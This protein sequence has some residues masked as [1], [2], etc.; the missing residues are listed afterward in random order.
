MDG[1]WKDGVEPSDGPAAEKVNWDD[2]R[3][4]MGW[5]DLRGGLSEVSLAMLTVSGRE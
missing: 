1:G 4:K 3:A 5:S 2:A